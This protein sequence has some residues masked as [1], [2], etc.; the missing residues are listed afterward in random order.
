VTSVSIH[1]GPV[2]FVAVGFAVIFAV[3]AAFLFRLRRLSER[4]QNLVN[5]V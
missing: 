2:G 1:D 5:V 3:P 4:L